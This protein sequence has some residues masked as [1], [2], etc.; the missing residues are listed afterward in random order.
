MVLKGILIWFLKKYLP[1]ANSDIWTYLEAESPEFQNLLFFSFY[2]H[3]IKQL[4]YVRVGL[5]PLEVNLAAYHKKKKN[6]TM[7]GDVC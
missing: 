5:H 1:N 6:L 3:N 7:Y 4:L 2:S